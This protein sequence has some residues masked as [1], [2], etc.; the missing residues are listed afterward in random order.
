MLK[1]KYYIHHY[2]CLGILLLGVCAYGVLNALANVY[3]EAIQW[4]YCWFLLIYLFSAFL[5]IIQKYLM[6]IEY[7]NAYLIVAGEGLYGIILSGFSFTI[8]NEHY[9]NF[10]YPAEDNTGKVQ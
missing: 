7:V 1:Y 3:K 4:K 10:I 2:I 6:D 9:P 8:L 5:G